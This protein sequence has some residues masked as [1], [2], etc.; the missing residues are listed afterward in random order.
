M[1]AR[2][3]RRDHVFINISVCDGICYSISC[4][5]CMP[6]CP[7]AF[8]LSKVEGQFH[9]NGLRSSIGNW[10]DPSNTPL[11][12]LFTMGLGMVKSSYHSEPANRPIH[13]NVRY[14][15]YIALGLAALCTLVHS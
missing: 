7:M 13:L 9:S 14:S 12:H 11:D 2:T 15:L 8:K 5:S 10:I 6:G 1:A 4:F 3:T